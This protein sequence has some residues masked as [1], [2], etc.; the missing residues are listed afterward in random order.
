MS[1]PTIALYYDDY[2]REMDA[3]LV[4]IRPEGL[5]L[6][7]TVFYPR[8]GN[9]DGDQGRLYHGDMSL[10]VEAVLKDTQGII[11]HRPATP[12]PPTWQPGTPLHGVLDWER[13]LTLMRLHTAQ[14]L[15]S[16]WFLDHGANGTVRVDITVAGCTIELERAVTVAQAL[17]C[18]DD[19]NTLILAGRPVQR[20]DT[21]G[22]LEIAVAGYDRQPCGGTHV[23]NIAEI[24]Q[25]AFT[26][27]KGQRLELCCATAAAAV[28][29]QMATAALEL[30]GD[31]ETDVEGFGARVRAL[32]AE[33]QAQKSALFRLGEEVAT[34]RVDRALHT[35]QTIQT[36]Q[37]TA[38]SVYTVELEMVESKNL[39]RL[40]KPVQA[41]GRVFLC[42][43]AGR[44]LTV[45]SGSPDLPATTL[46][47]RIKARYQL[48]GGGSP[49][50]AQCGP[51]PTESTLA[52]VRT[53]ASDL[54]AGGSG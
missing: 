10:P 25:I 21:D 6:D 8:G 44:N 34:A 1:E 28:Q 35:P 32:R 14:H 4:E 17:D 39:P 18:Q 49:V 48:R 3:E 9:Q 36:P 40:L 50:V 33:T 42:L 29:R 53:L 30:A 54:L 52:M 27:V 19:L 20:I 41:L 37:G 51:L 15:I 43:C 5:V 46:V 23:R 26:R 31:L 38:V 2:A 12:A 7:R 16:R 45:I 11:T 13:R 22:Y 24:Q 47:D